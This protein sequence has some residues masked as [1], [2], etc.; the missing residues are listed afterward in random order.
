[1]GHILRGLGPRKKSESDSLSWCTH[2]VQMR[3]LSCSFRVAVLLLVRAPDVVWSPVL[4]AS[5]R[6]LCHFADWLHS[7]WL[8]AVVGFVPRLATIVV[9]AFKLSTSSSFFVTPLRD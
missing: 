6:P 7:F 9:F 4:L 8:S 2:A 1:M 5:G 3:R